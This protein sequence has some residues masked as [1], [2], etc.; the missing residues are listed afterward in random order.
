MIY[1]V[2]GI[3]LKRTNLAEADRILTVF[4]REKGKIKVIAKGVRKTLSK[5]AGHLELFCLVDLRLAEGRN[6]DII[7]DAQ[8]KKCFLNLRG[9]LRSTTTA[10]YLTEITEKMTA[11][12][13]KHPEIFDLLLDVLQDVNQKQSQLLVSYF[14]LNFLNESGFK[15]ELYRCLLCHGKILPKDNYFSFQEGGLVCKNCSNTTLNFKISDS[16]IKVLRLFLK[17][18]LSFVDKIKLDQKTVKEV[19][20]ITHQYLQYIHQ[21]EF[22]SHKFLKK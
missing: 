2:Q 13:Q 19:S 11:E 14:E 22:N 4:T 10:Y 5:L 3:V 9:N 18:K 12:N 20:K 8:V 6:L 16:A 15:P 21:K 1:K 17:H 7:T